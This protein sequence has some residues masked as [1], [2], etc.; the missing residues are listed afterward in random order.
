MEMGLVGGFIVFGFMG[1]VFWKRGFG[2][3]GVL[4]FDDFNSFK[5]HLFALYN[6]SSITHK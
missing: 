4:H 5:I 3:C 2:C 6:T 1:I